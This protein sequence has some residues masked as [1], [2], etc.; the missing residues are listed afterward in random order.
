VNQKGEIGLGGGHR[1]QLPG[2][3][4]KELRTGKELGDIIDRWA[5]GTDIKKKEGTIGILTHN[6]ITRTKMFEDVVICSFARFMK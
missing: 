5:G 1:L 2:E 6:H 4:A 3:V